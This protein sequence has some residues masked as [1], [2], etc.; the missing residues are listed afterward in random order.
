MDFTKYAANMWSTQDL[1]IRSAGLPVH[2]NHLA[3]KREGTGAG[4]E[5]VNQTEM[6]AL[7]AC[8]ARRRAIDN[9]GVI[10]TRIEIPAQA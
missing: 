6:R 8:S 4:L 2:G 7:L 3:T 10:K 5:H 9:I 1:M